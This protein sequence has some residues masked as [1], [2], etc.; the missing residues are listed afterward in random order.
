MWN[1]QNF[2]NNQPSTPPPNS[3]IITVIFKLLLRNARGNNEF[4]IQCSLNDKVSDVIQKFKTKAQ[5]DENINHE[6]FKFN[7][8]RLNET[9]TVAEV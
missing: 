2:P 5:D 1:Q 7:A 4:T 6:K 8:K 9:L 3:N